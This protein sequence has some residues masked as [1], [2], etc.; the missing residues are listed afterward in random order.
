MATDMTIRHTEEK[1][2]ALAGNDSTRK[3]FCLLFII[4]IVLS[5][6]A[7]IFQTVLYLNR[8]D[9][10]LML[11]KRGQT[12]TVFYIVCTVVGILLLLSFLLFRR[13]SVPQSLAQPGR[14]INFAALFCGF[15]LASS[16]L[17]YLIYFLSGI[18]PDMSVLRMAS[19]VTAL[20][21]ALYFL[22]TALSTQPSRKL[23]AL[24]GFFIVIWGL[25]FLLNLY[26]DMSVPMTSPARPLGY[27]SLFAIMFYFL[28]EIRFILGSAKP[29]L[30][31]SVSLMSIFVLSLT[32]VPNFIL[33]ATGLRTSN[34]S[35]F[36][37]AEACILFYILTRMISVLTGRAFILPAEYA[38][39]APRREK[40][41]EE[42]E[43]SNSDGQ[44]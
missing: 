30:Y 23:L 40:D 18:T 33:I 12:P 14:L 34:D 41:E 39:E 20:P 24:S 36:H 43:E 9:E 37:I 19:I 1:K 35:I 31:L 15:F 38:V 25:L 17:L 44:N 27:L 3:I 26:F 11:Y 13:D 10:T 8:Y 2:S 4:T 22:V 21:A 29:R 42:D 28:L 32:C 6:A 16:I 5:L 7:A